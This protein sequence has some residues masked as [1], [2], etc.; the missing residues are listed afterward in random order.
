[1]E[2]RERTILI[3]ARTISGQDRF[4]S[5]Y[6]GSAY[7]TNDENLWGRTVQASSVERSEIGVVEVIQVRIS[8]IFT[9]EE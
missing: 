7:F 8:L 6:N 2:F 9:T 4:S 5:S 1:V 3:R